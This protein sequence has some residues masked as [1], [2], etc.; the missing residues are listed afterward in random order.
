MSKG[1]LKTI[2]GDATN[3][4]LTD[5]NE[6]A[7]IPHVCNDAG[8]WGAGFVVALSKRWRHPEE[9]Y[10]R[11]EKKLGSI[12]TV[13]I[14]DGPVV[15]NMIAQR[16]YIDSEMNPRP[17]KYNALVECMEKVGKT[18]A[19]INSVG[20]E[21]YVIHCPKFGS[22]LAGGRWEFILD[23]IEDIWLNKGLDVVVYEFR[24]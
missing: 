16:G 5:D 3:P 10:R 15:I 17:L 11:M 21:K 18:Y 8:G 1:T 14:G 9:G 2:V 12:S 19:A 7:V 22:D 4:Q 6:V 24:G 13:N 20:E 23:L